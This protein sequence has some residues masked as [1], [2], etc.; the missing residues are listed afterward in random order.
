[1]TPDR[2]TRDRMLKHCGQLHEDDGVDPREYFKTATNR[3]KPNRKVLQLCSQVAQ[4]LNLVL[5]G[6]F[7]DEFLH[8]LQVE[9]VDPAPNASQLCVSVSCLAADETVPPQE[10]LDRLAK[11]AGRLR[12][13][14]AA[15]ITRK[16]AP[17]LVFRVVSPV[18][19]GHTEP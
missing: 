1:M 2:R 10:I 18:E 8:N 3:G 6:E 17:K 9:S 16:R 15:A 19:P 14:V 12:A 7:D 5:A 4:T 13:Q 11:V